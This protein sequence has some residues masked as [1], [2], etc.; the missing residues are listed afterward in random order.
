MKVDKKQF[1]AAIMALIQLPALPK[2]EI[3]A[4]KENP[5]RDQQVRALKKQHKALKKP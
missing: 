3:P 1:D 5:K 4:K 2:S